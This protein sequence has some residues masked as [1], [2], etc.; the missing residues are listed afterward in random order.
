ML[1]N[2]VVRQGERKLFESYD[3][4][5]VVTE[6][7]PWDCD[8]HECPLGFFYPSGWDRMVSAAGAGHFPSPGQSDSDD[9]P[10]GWVNDSP[11][12]TGL[13][14]NKSSGL[15]QNGSSPLSDKRPWEFFLDIYCG[16]LVWLLERILTVLA[17]PPTPHLDPLD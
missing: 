5:S 15:F 17:H 12:S 10:A 9:T 16:T 6:P 8:L 13:V 3:L 11:L 2:M 7:G 4:V 1:N 14:K